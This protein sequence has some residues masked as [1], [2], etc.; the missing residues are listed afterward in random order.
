LTLLL[1]LS[2]TTALAQGHRPRPEHDLLTYEVVYRVPAMDKV[3]VAHDVAY[4]KAGDRTLSVDLYYPPG[5]KAGQS[6][7]A[8][9]FVN[10][11]GDRPGDVKVKD[12]GQYRS[13]P[14]LVAARG[15]IGISM[16]SRSG[17]ANGE[18]V[19]DALRWARTDG[20][21]K[22]IDP[23]RVAAWACSANVSAAV[24][25]LMAEG[26]PPAR[27]AVLY[28]GGVPATS[29]RSDL[30][31]LLVRAG[32]DQA[33]TNDRLKQMLDAALAANAPWTLV[34]LPGLH[35]AFDCLD[36]NDD[37]RAA[38]GRTLAFLESSL[39]ATP[40]GPLPTPEQARLAPGNPPK[41]ARD[42]MAHFFGREWD[43]AEK[44]YTA[45]TGKRPDDADAWRMLGNAQV[46]AKRLDG[47][48]TSLKRAIEL[49]PE[50]GE[51]YA[52]LGRIEAESRNY[53]AAIP[54]LEKAIQSMPDDAEAHHQL[55]GVYLVQKRYPES[56][57]EL[58]AAVRLTPWNG[59]AWNK[60]GIAS[61]ATDNP[62]RAV[63]SFQHVL[64]YVPQDPAV[65]YN[66]ACAQAR[67]GNT[68]E[69]L[70]TLGRSIDNGYKD[71]KNLV[72]DT[73]LVSLRSEPRF[74]ELVQKLPE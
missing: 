23:A 19:R 18:D 42:A 39:R 25:V 54:L 28:Y 14:R 49:S 50:N 24:P 73:D 46:E 36:D 37:S 53:D 3:T 40:P 63:E 74:Q 57:R 17:D 71:R 44:A 11:V 4:K 5:Y 33:F 60:L 61:L 64:Q 29:F 7:P 35:H 2:T 68:A 55:G 10:G 38:I 59:Y 20:Q 65:L 21:A 22:G 48:R 27:A 51:S 67:A 34:N 1:A 47:A 41:E 32:R 43:D 6:L 69:A 45:W 52:M 15:M 16:E 13:W 72:S 26:E 56:V 70:D 62:A 12:W 31:V 58:E 9:L 66:M 8:V 30:P